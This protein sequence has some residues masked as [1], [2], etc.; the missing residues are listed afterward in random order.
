MKKSIVFTSLAAL[1][2]GVSGEALADPAHTDTGSTDVPGVHMVLEDFNCLL[3]DVKDADGNKV[4]P[5]GAN[6]GQFFTG[7]GIGQDM[8]VNAWLSGERDVTALEEY[9]AKATFITFMLMGQGIE[10]LDPGSELDQALGCR[11]I[12]TMQGV[13]YGVA[14]VINEVQANCA[15]DGDYWSP[16]AAG[17]F[18]EF[19]QLSN[20]LRIEGLKNHSPSLCGIAFEGACKAGFEDLA[21][22]YTSP[23]VA[24]CNH[25]VEHDPA[26]TAE[27]EHNLCI[28]T[29]TR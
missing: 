1:T 21:R 12:G 4:V 15:A 16:F 29:E 22:A 20:G 14:R 17:L 28:Y 3:G 2:L 10:K 7:F 18:C 13:T 25:W 11:F 26:V 9:V 24:D 5:K 8:A 27:Q 19:S 23:N 6:T